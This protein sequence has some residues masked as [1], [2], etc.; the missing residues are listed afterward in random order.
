MTTHLRA[1]L[2]TKVANHLKLTGES[3]VRVASVEALPDKSGVVVNMVLQSNGVT[4]REVALAVG[5]SGLVS[6]LRTAGNQAAYVPE[7][8]VTVQNVEAIPVFDGSDASPDTSSRG[9]GG[10]EGTGISVS[11]LLVSVGVTALVVGGL[12]V[13]VQRCRSGKGSS[14]HRVLRMTREESELIHRQSFHSIPRS[15]RSTPSRSTAGSSMSRPG[16][17]GCD[18]FAE[19]SVV[20]Q[21]DDGFVHT[22][23]LSANPLSRV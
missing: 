20:V 3:A 13:V 12:S 11:V 4:A 8:G 21:G 14:G 9:N 18:D 19:V 10:Q 6:S 1:A 7:D 5:W 23:R 17:A 16:S 2:A 15:G 22:K